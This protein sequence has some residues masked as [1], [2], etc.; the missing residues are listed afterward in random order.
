ME[1]FGEVLSYFKK[2]ESVEAISP[3]IEDQSMRDGLV[4][5]KSVV[6]RIYRNENCTLTSEAERWNWLWDCTEF[7]I[8]DFGSVAG[9]KQCDASLLFQRLKGYRLIYPDGTINT[10]AIKFLQAHIMS[11]LP[12][13]KKE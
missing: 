5:W 2:I 11:K 7:S 4:A 13:A 10:W 6:I 1:T 12:K 3:I 9:V 8:A